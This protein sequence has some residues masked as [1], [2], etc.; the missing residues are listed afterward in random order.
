[1]LARE[2]DPFALPNIAGTGPRGGSVPIELSRVM[3][4]VPVERPSDVILAQ[5]GARAS[6]REL[7]FRPHEADEL[8]IVAS[9]LATNILRYG[10]R[11]SIRFV[12]VND[13]ARGP[14]LE[15]VARDLGP[16]FRDFAT[17]LED[18]NDD[19][20]PI[21]FEA[22]IGRVG[23][24]TGLGAVKRFSDLLEYVP[25]TEAGKEIRAVRFVRRTK[26]GMEGDR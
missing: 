15:I 23:S 17:A 2:N 24:A 1:M 10:I 20:G 7:G 25:A 11:G 5:R 19:N 18:G 13:P 3:E 26:R 6:A 8:A 4:T 9:E 21:A 16:P 14:G 12:R 22:R